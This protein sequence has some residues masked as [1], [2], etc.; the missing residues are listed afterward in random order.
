MRLT[1]LKSASV[2]VQTAS[3]R[4]ICGPWL[5]NGEY[6]GAWHHA[7]SYPFAPATFANFDAIV[8]THIHPDH[9]SRKTL[10]LM[11]RSLPVYILAFHAKFLRRGIE[12]LGFVVHEIEHGHRTHVAGDLF[13]TAASADNC[14]PQLCARFLGCPSQSP[15]LL[16]ANIDSLLLFD[17]GTHSILNVNDCP[18]GLAE[19]A[20]KTLCETVE[21]VD[22]LLV[23]YGG[24]GP[25]PQCFETLP[26]AE[27]D[28]AA[29]RK[30]LTFLNQAEAFINA[31]RP[32]L[33][34]PFAG[35]Y[36]L[37]G[38]LYDLN[39]HRG[40]PPRGE[41]ANFLMRSN[42]V[43]HRESSC[44][45][46]HTD[47][48]VE[49]SVRSHETCGPRETLD[50]DG[51]PTPSELEALR[52]SGFDFDSD[53]VPSPDELLRLL[54]DAHERFESVRSGLGLG[55]TTALYIPIA[56][57]ESARLSLSDGS[58]SVVPQIRSF[59]PPFVSLRVEPRLLKR[60]LMGPAHAHW[61]NAEIGSHISFGR[62]GVPYE[63]GL[64]HCVNFLHA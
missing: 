15:L 51:S 27:R 35:T 7:Q 21:R 1:Y 4:V 10:A 58:L 47:E 20:V 53:P 60:L 63:R 5:V 3:A 46:L 64:H 36:T 34:M 9:C 43:N 29:A 48:S 18:F 45:F 56:D 42:R 62:V 31:V 30:Q 33:Y 37:G 61:N 55:T 50:D 24:A 11:P 6:Y 52:A 49:L 44:V 41:A 2:V 14:D 16:N 13:V 19:T 54:K 28:Q 17:D 57:N 39:P 8:I 22:L 38:R 40:L 32:R 25:F 59:E 23:G 26:P 12:Q